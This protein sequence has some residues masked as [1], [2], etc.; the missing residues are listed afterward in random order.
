MMSLADGACTLSPTS[1]HVFAGGADSSKEHTSMTQFI[2]LILSRMT[3]AREDDR[4]A[5]MVEYGLLVVLIA[6]VGAIGAT[7][8]G[9]NLQALFTNID[10][11]P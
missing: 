6:L 10:L 5:T 7:V 2:S 11:T 9:V 1:P 4:G 3:A 8:L